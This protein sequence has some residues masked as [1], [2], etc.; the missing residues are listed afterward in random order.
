VRNY[1]EHVGEQIEN[2]MRTHWE[3]KIPMPPTPTTKRKK[4]KNLRSPGWVHA[5]S[6]HW[7]QDFFLMASPCS[8]P[9]L[10]L[11]KGRSMNFG[12]V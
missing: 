2:L 10:G 8:L 3:Q 5:A 11:A 12:S 1:W 6:P 4:K 9:F 7:L